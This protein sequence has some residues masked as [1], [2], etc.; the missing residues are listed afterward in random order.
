VNAFYPRRRTKAKASA[1]AIA[2]N[3]G[4][5]VRESTTDGIGDDGARGVAIVGSMVETMH[6]VG[7]SRATHEEPLL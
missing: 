2:A 4:S 1:T 3:V 6:T 7:W 5:A